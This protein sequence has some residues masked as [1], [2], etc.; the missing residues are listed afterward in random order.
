MK[1]GTEI[2]VSVEIADGRH[3]RRNVNGGAR[4][5]ESSGL[6]DGKRRVTKEQLGW[7]GLVCSLKG[8]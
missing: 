3:W 1:I 4:E 2:L 7:G 8:S 5:A 6:M